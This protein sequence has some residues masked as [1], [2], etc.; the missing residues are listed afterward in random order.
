MGPGRCS[1]GPLLVT[2]WSSVCSVVDPLSDLPPRPY[3]PADQHHQVPFG[4]RLDE[5]VVLGVARAQ[6]KAVADGLPEQEDQGEHDHVQSREDQQ[7]DQGYAQNHREDPEY[8]RHQQLCRHDPP[9]PEVV[10]VGGVVED[11]VGVVGEGDGHHNE[12]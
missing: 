3:Q 6:R 12:E 1:S 4:E 9:R 7:D 11:G 5:A 8:Q 2:H 10:Q